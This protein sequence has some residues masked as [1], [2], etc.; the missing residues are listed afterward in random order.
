MAVVLAVLSRFD[1]AGVRK[2]QRRLEQFGSSARGFAGSTAADM[3]RAGASMERLGGRIAKVGDRMSTRF[4]LPVVAA[5]G[6]A[7]KAAIDEQQEIA[8]LDQALRKNTDATDA[9]VAAVERWITKTQN[10]SGVADGELRPAL[11]TLLTATKDTGKAQEL[12]GVA[13]DIAAAKGK[14]VGTVATALMK[15]YNGNTSALGRLGVKTKDAN[16]NVMSFEQAMKNA[17]QTFGGSA[18]RA[19]DTAAGR[20]AILQARLE[21]TA[22]SVGTSLIPIVERGAVAIGRIADKFNSLSPRMQGFI[23]KALLAGAALGPALSIGGRFAKVAGTMLKA[24]GNIGI[25]MG[26][27][28][29]AAPAWARGVVGVT[30]AARSYAASAA[31]MLASLGRQAA[32]FAVATAKTIANT[33]ATLASRAAQLAASAAS[34]A[35]AAAQWLLNVALSANPIGLVV[36]AIAGLVVAFVI[37]WKKSDAFRRIV[38]KAWEAIKRTALAVFNGLVGFFKRWGTLVLRVLI[39]PLGNLVIEVVKHWEEIKAAAAEKFGAV[40]AF[41]RELPG[42]IKSAVGDLGR[43]L[44][45]AGADLLRGLWEGMQSI[46]GWLKDKIVGFFS[47]LLPGWVKKALGISSPSRVF[48]EIGRN[49]AAGMALGIEDGRRRV[50]EATRSLVA[51]TGSGGQLAVSLAGAGGVARETTRETVIR[52]RVAAAAQPTYVSV[53]LDSEPIAARVEVSQRRKA[54]RAARLNGTW[55]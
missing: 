20:M 30:R 38:T 7:T 44:Y 28:A 55:T 42:R 21:D 31:K 2:A 16:G 9:Q 36:A 25:A 33:A 43:V 26:E 23:T 15:A 8:L 10:W 34:K 5:F 19:A 48:A 40:V 37:A 51:A 46:A 22:E 17:E 52:E 27:N 39:G 11:A 49:V 54:R 3:V 12:M 47:D 18:A 32:A 24:A 6:F 4:T 45:D 53:Y 29:K 1:D 41:A 35:W 14:D 50:G 13:L